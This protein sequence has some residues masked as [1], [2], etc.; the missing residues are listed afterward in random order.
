ME[1]VFEFFKN[2]YYWIF[3][4]IGIFLLGLILKF[5]RS[6]KK[7]QYQKIGD[8]SRGFQAGES[9]NISL[10]NSKSKKEEKE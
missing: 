2:N 5:F 8:H 3:S 7:N 9:I 6:K 10:N 1:K 4:G